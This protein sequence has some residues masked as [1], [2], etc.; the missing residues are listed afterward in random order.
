MPPATYWH[1]GAGGLIVTLSNGLRNVEGVAF[2]PGSNELWVTVNERD[3]LGAR[4]PADFL[5]HVRQGDFFG[6]P[7]AYNGPNPDPVFGAKRPDLVKKSKTPDVLFEA[8]SA[9]LG[10][11]F[12]TGKQFPANYRCDAVVAFHG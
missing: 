11:V 7:Y 2:Y 3:A 8:H 4:V 10:L 1:V 5:A 6:W 9:P 12:Y